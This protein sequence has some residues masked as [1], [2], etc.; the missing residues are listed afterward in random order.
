M[1]ADSMT[2]AYGAGTRRAQAAQA[3]SEAEKLD[4]EGI[5]LQTT[6]HEQ[7]S[8]YEPAMFQA[9]SSPLATGDGSR[10]L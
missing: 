8:K 10:R 1:V 7:V 5:D 3:N 4:A 9:I 2:A 6:S